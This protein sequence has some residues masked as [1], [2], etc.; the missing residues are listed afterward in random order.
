MMR[1]IVLGTTNMLDIDLA[2]KSCKFGNVLVFSS[3][4]HIF[5][6]SLIQNRFPHWS[7]CILNDIEELLLFLI[8]LSYFPDI[9][10]QKEP[11]WVHKSFEIQQM[12]EAHERS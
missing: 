7:I 5:E 2:N 8:E 12:P 1:I 10:E 6:E 3:L 4:C 9:F 11:N